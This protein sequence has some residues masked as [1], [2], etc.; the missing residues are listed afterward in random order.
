MPVQLFRAS[1]GLATLVCM[2]ASSQRGSP[3]HAGLAPPPHMDRAASCR[4]RASPRQGPIQ[5][6]LGPGKS[7][8]KE[9]NRD[10]CSV[11]SFSPS[12]L[13][14][15]A[16]SGDTLEAAQTEPNVFHGSASMSSG[17]M[18]DEEME[19]LQCSVILEEGTSEGCGGHTRD[20]ELK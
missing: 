3:Q 6:I 12:M 5:S 15:E 13:C 10:G 14:T 17:D 1:P 9:G 18:G 7:S 20:F 16:S 2:V 19:Q 8:H 11:G 4:H